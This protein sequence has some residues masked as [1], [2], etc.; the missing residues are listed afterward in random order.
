MRVLHF[1]SSARDF[2]P[3]F[4]GL[5]RSL[6]R[7][8]VELSVCTMEPEW[9]FHREL[10]ALGIRAYGLGLGVEGNRLRA[11]WQLRGL[12]AVERPQIL[13]LHLFW[14]ALIGLLAARGLRKR[15]AC[16][17][18]RHYS[19]FKYTQIDSV[20]E[21]EGYLALERLLNRLTDRLIV[22]SELT[23]DIILRVE[24]MPP[25]KV[26]RIPLGFEFDEMQPPSLSSVE[27]LRREMGLDGHFVIGI[28]GRLSKEKGHHYLF[29]A[30]SELPPG[31]SMQWKL[32]VVGD[33]PLRK[34]LEHQVTEHNLREQVIFTGFSDQ[35]LAMITLMDLVV[36]PS[37]HEAFSRT[38]VET[39]AL[40]KPLIITE[41]SGVH[42]VVRDGQNGLIVPQRDPSALAA[43]IRRVID[44]PA[45][46]RQIAAQGAR[47]VRGFT[48]ERMAAAYQSCYQEVLAEMGTLAAVS[49]GSRE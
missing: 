38:M 40:G 21:R 32:L 35:P 37:L 34:Q 18:T 8:A 17:V 16:V 36:Q 13:H 45:W 5:A 47:D 3:F 33:G 30:L 29:Q 46:A 43:A 44:S 10:V 42:E 49:D 9:G 12:L 11:F 26:V 28:I 22:L 1:I 4:F 39:L 20:L 25:T 6:D 41:V 27:A 19:D 23:E 7:T 24:R 2:R 15:P 48:M 14:P 31:G